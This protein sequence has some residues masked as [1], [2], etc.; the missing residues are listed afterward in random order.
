MQ[1]E[2]I[3][4]YLLELLMRLSTD[5]GGEIPDGF[6]HQTG[7]DGFF[8]GSP[9]DDGRM[10]GQGRRILRDEE[11]VELEVEIEG[12]LIELQEMGVFSLSSTE[13][14]LEKLREE[15]SEGITPNEAIQLASSILRAEQPGDF[16]QGTFMLEGFADD[17]TP[18]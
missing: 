10:R 8:H 3:E 11:R 16:R 12:L 7:A 4:R 13:R 14:F 15:G 17:M 9:L 1:N 2:L 18:H 5:E 6:F